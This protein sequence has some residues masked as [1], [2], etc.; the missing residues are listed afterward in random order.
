MTKYI[1][2]SDGTYP[3]TFASLRRDN[4]GVSYPRTPSDEDLA[5]WG[6]AAVTEVA[7]PAYDPAKNIVEGQPTESN[8]VWTQVWDQ[9]DATAEQIAR[10]EADAKNLAERAEIK[11]DN[12][13]GTFIGMTPAEVRAYIGANV[14]NLASA[15]G[16]IEK[17]AVMVLLL[18][19]REFKD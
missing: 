7:R 17:L 11:L 10:R 14:T 18:A 4:P 8:G 2:I 5:G 6:V 15:K 3:Y 13:V 9:L 12:F 19:R 1:K 16:V